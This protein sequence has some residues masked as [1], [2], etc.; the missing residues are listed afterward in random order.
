[1][2]KWIHKHGAIQILVAYTGSPW[3]EFVLGSLLASN[4]LADVSPVLT[5]AYLP[6]MG[7]A[8][9]QMLGRFCK[10]TTLELGSDESLDL[11]G[12]QQLPS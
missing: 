10:L 11:H 8:S 6:E 4:V 9:L 7:H 1:M 5:E 3:V 2:I 12:L